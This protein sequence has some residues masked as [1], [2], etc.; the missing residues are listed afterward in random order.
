[1]KK[2]LALIGIAGAVALAAVA[3]TSIELYSRQVS[4]A[5][6]YPTNAPVAGFHLNLY[7]NDP[8]VT[9]SLPSIMVTSTNLSATATNLAVGTKYWAAVT[10]F[11]AEGLESPPSNVITFQVPA[12]PT[13]VRILVR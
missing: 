3:S 13:N 12:Q 6:D 11:S 4:F 8:Q 2:K 5:W 7:T 9:A 1:M 10:A